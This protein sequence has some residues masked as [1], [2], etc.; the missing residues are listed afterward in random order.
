MTENSDTSRPPSPLNLAAYGFVRRDGG[1]V[2]S[3]NHLVLERLLDLGHHVEF[4]AIGGFVVPEGL[5]G[6]NGFTYVPISVPSIRLGWRTLERL[7]PSRFRRIPEFAYSLV[8]NALHERAIAR[9]LSRRHASRPFDALLVLGLLAPFRV[10]GLPCVSWPQGPPCAEWEALESQKRLVIRYGGRSLYAVLKRLYRHKTRVCRRQFAQSD[11]IVGCSRWSAEAWSHSGGDRG[12]LRAV[13]YAYDLDAFR[14]VDRIVE[15]PHVTRFLWLGRIVPRK[16]LDLLLDTFALLRA[17]RS[18]VELLIVGQ[19]AYPRGLRRL[20]DESRDIPG[21]VYRESIARDAV[22]ELFRKVDVVVQPS[23]NEN[24]G[25]AVL[26]G[27]CCGIPA[28]VGPSNGSKDYLG[29]SSIVFDAYTPQ[30]LKAAMTRLA[31]DVQRDRAGTA[32][33]C[34]AAAERFLSVEVV[35][36]GILA[37]VRDAISIVAGEVTR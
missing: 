1:S 23:E 11:I 34:R 22:P 8:S 27:I 9:E 35:T 24:L 15:S 25:S 28:V 33:T 13:P 14:P 29:A 30:S 2:A 36:D 32:A 20:L 3:A 26:E 31:V 19:F 4:H 6:R 18:D 5:I 12:K 21:I 7:I 10:K 37:A 17:E 16:R